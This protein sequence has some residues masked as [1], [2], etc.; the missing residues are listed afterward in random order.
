[1]GGE[2]GADG[3]HGRFLE[4]QRAG[5]DERA[6][7]GNIRMAVLVGIAHGQYPAIRQL[8]TARTL[9]LEK[10]QRHRVVH[11]RDYVVLGRT[12]AVADL[13]ATVVRHNTLTGEPAAQ[14]LALDLGLDRKS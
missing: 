2:P 14:A 5:F 11:P 3:R 9:D 13:G 1:M 12:L 10:E 7:D 8:H 4:L 6:P